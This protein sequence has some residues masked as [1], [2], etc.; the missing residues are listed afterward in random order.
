MVVADEAATTTLLLT[1]LIPTQPAVA[2]ERLVAA[3]AEVV[4]VPMAGSSDVP[5]RA[6]SGSRTCHPVLPVVVLAR[7]SA[8]QSSMR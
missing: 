4:K 8:S 5:R 6:E 7:S 2:E 3:A 1:F